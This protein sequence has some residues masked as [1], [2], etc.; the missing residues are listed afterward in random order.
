MLQHTPDSMEL[1]ERSPMQTPRTPSE[2]SCMSERWSTPDSNILASSSSGGDPRTTNANASA[3]QHSQ[4]LLGGPSIQAQAPKRRRSTAAC[5]MLCRAHWRC[6]GCFQTR[7]ACRGLTFLLLGVLALY[8]AKQACV[9]PSKNRAHKA[10]AGLHVTSIRLYNSQN[11]CLVGVDHHRHDLPVS[12]SR[13]SLQMMAQSAS[14]YPQVVSVQTLITEAASYGPAGHL[15]PSETQMLETRRTNLSQGTI[16][17]KA[18]SVSDVRCS[19]QRL[20][21]EGSPLLERRTNLSLSLSN[22]SL[23]VCCEIGGLT[24]PVR[25]STVSNNENSYQSTLSGLYACGTEGI[26]SPARSSIVSTGHFQSDLISGWLRGLEGSASPVRPLPAPCPAGQHGSSLYVPRS[27]LLHQSAQVQPGPQQS[28]VGGTVVHLNPNNH[29]PQPTQA[30]SVHTSATWSGLSEP[31]IEG[32]SSPGASLSPRASQGYRLKL[33]PWMY[34]TPCCQIHCEPRLEGSSSPT[35]RFEAPTSAQT[36]PPASCTVCL[37]HLH[38]RFSDI[39]HAAR[40]RACTLRAAVAVDQKRCTCNNRCCFCLRGVSGQSCC[41]KQPP[42][43]VRAAFDT[44]SYVPVVCVPTAPRRRDRGTCCR[45]HAMIRRLSLVVAHSACTCRSRMVHVLYI[46]VAG[47]LAD[48]PPWSLVCMPQP[49]LR[50]QQA[51]CGERACFPKVPLTPPWRVVTA[52]HTRSARWLEG[53]TSPDQR[54]A[55]TTSIATRS[56]SCT[57]Q[58]RAAGDSTHRLREVEASAS[59]RITGGGPA[60][61]GG[62]LD[63]W[64][65]HYRLEGSA[66]PC[67]TLPTAWS[68]QPGPQEQPGQL[69]PGIRMSRPAQCTLHCMLMDCG[70]L[71]RTSIGRRGLRAPPPGNKGHRLGAVGFFTQYLR[72]DTGEPLPGSTFLQ[73]GNSE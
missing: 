35:G 63:D 24:L 13:N 69:G 44:E 1:L 26:S 73:K 20:S 4:A 60:D 27:W 54:A 70:R 41:A 2:G 30:R 14:D 3:S 5:K 10:S 57:C 38:L 61:L 8:S 15:Y 46:T 67:C 17:T 21:T 68:T 6:I 22:T 59:N 16:L 64:P 56:V 58:D 66:S 45:E 62:Q 33:P 40:T 36:W 9:Q 19:Q 48:R 23:A 65:H 71:H 11:N 28:R 7:A 55:L 47:A 43:A 29:S 12:L 18:A 42:L 32:H 72:S 37:Q 49:S 31:G 25:P 53:S 39:W 34:I 50:C 52:A 51:L